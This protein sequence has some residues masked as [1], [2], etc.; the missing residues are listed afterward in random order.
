MPVRISNALFYGIVVLL[1]AWAFSRSP[2]AVERSE[3]IIEQMNAS[4]VK[5]DIRSY[6]T[7]ISCYGRSKEFGAPQKADKVLRYMDTLYNQGALKEGPS[8][9]T[10]LSLRK[11]WEVSSEPDKDDAIASLD[12][13]IHDRFRSGV[14][15]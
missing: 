5:P 3:Q 13:E 12:K 4:N 14:Q 2:N 7:L 1:K 8:I 6:T 11:A 15:R 9:H 10:F